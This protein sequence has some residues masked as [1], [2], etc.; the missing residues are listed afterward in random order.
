MNP[1]STAFDP[2]TLLEQMTESVLVTTPELDRPGPEI[3]YVN[4]AFEAMTGWSRDEMLGKSPRILQ[5]P[6]TDLTVFGNLRQCLANGQVWHGQTI[7]YRKDGSA[8]VMEW[9]IAP[10]VDDR[11]HPVVGALQSEK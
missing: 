3:L 8:F 6:N 9:S 1:P 10:L 11:K 4:P 5:G 2:W 7:N